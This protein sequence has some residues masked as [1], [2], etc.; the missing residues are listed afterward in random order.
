MTDAEKDHLKN[1]L[2][3]NVRY[4]GRKRDEFREVSIEKGVIA[5]AEGSA[6]VKIGATEV[7][8][9]VKMELGTPYSDTPDEGSLMVGAEF[10]AMA[11]PD[12]ETGAPGIDAIE[13]ARV[14]D[15]GIREGGAMDV[16]KLCIEEGKAA[17]TVIVDICTVNNAGSLQDASALAAVAAL[18]DAVFPEIKEVGEDRK[19]VDY[20]HKTDKHLPL[21][22]KPINVTVFKRDEYLF[23]DPT[24]SEEKFYDARLS[25]AV[26][27]DGRLCALQKGGEGI[28]T[29]EDISNMV[30]LAVDKSQVL[31]KAL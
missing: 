16:K 31:R 5:T 14:V 13:L 17:W 22:E 3:E 18:Q 15:R 21:D 23:V 1:A 10:L 20:K 26:L 30:K 2:A 24:D 28:L 8:A 27:E 29:A 6:R 12:F 11:H 7:L 19:E 25:V 9:G 4:D